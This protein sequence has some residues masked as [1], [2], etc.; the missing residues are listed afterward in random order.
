VQAFLPRSPWSMSRRL[1]ADLS[2]SLKWWFKNAVL[3]FGF[4]H[5]TRFPSVFHDLYAGHA[6]LSIVSEHVTWFFLQRR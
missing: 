6:E 3:S 1:S 2:K 4:S 5:Y